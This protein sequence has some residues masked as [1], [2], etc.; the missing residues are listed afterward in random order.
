[1]IGQ[2]LPKDWKEKIASF[3]KFMKQKVEMLLLN[4]SQI[5]NMDEVPMSFDMLTSC[6]ADFI[7]VKSVPVVMT[8][9]EKNT[10]TVVPSCMAS[11]EKLP[12][13]VIFK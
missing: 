5:G 8:G 3:F 12:T 1:M 2:K 13:L 10:F 11:S 6:S 4:L 7:Q 9:N